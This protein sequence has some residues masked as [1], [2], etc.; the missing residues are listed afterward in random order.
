MSYYLC[1]CSVRVRHPDVR[2][3]EPQHAGGVTH[4]HAPPRCKCASKPLI[5]LCPLQL[6]ECVMY[7]PLCTRG[8]DTFN[9]NG[10]QAYGIHLS[11]VP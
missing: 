10:L 6:A 11:H 9:M 7:G 2:A 5:L 3:V 4:R 1:C 8:L